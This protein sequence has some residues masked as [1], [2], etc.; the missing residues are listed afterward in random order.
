ME[1][2]RYVRSLSLLTWITTVLF[3]LRI[4]IT[5]LIPQQQ[6]S[7]FTTAMGNDPS[8]A[9]VGFHGKEQGEKRCLIDGRCILTNIRC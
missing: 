6:T 9:L 4:D 3:Y 5:A 8:A 7:K 1:Y 2:N